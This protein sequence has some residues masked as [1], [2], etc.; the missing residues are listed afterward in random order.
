MNATKPVLGCCLLIFSLSA[1]EVRAQ[2]IQ[3]PE[4]PAP[5]FVLDLELGVEYSDN[6][7][8]F[9]PPGPDDTLLIPR[10]VLDL[11]RTGRRWQAR[12]QG[13]AEY[14]HSLENEFDDEFRANLATLIDWILVP[15]SLIWTFQDVASVEPINLF[16][17]DAPDNLQQTNVLVTGPAWRIR[18]GTAWEALLDARFIHSYAEEIDGFNSERMSAAARLMR[19]MT[20]TR[21]ASLGVEFTD[22]SY[23]ESPSDLNDYERFD[24]FARLTSTQARTEL[25]VA[26][27]YT[28]IEPDHLGSTSSPLLRVAIDWRLLERGGLRLSA[29]HELS[30]SVRQLT[31]AIDAIDLPVSH[32]TRLPV[33]AELY[34]LD[35]AELGWYQATERFE[36][37]LAPAWRDYEFATDADLDYR[38]FG[39]TFLGSWRITPLMILR[40]R[41]EVERRRFDID[42]RRDTDY[43]GSL[44]LSRSFTPRW[45]GRVGAIRHERDSTAPGEDSRENIVAVFVTYHAGR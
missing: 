23:R 37:S 43:H 9:D 25:D 42:Q 31:T 1:F 41:V 27:G 10:L 6:R 14:R 17:V 11:S 36:W 45:S 44:F 7:G 15:E 38:E 19:R 8:R 28:W 16:A 2:S 12:A 32:T 39:G 26:A 21:N 29:R 5:A 40:A 33:G 24:T 20:P 34:E 22:V 13:F 35:E 3:E 30:D 18:A 4:D